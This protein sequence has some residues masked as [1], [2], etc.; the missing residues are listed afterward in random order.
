[1][2]GRGL[3]IG[4]PLTGQTRTNRTGIYRRLAW[5]GVIC[6][7]AGLAALLV[8]YR[9]S[10]NPLAVH[11]RD[12]QFAAAKAEL[13]VDTPVSQLGDQS[14]DPNLGLISH[15]AITD[16]LFLKSDVARR[17]AAAAAGIPGKEISVSGPFTL[18]IGRTNHPVTGPQI[19]EPVQEDKDYRLLVDVDGRHPMI[20]LYSQAPNTTAAVAIVDS[21]RRLLTRYVSEL[22]ST[23]HLGP[24]FRSVIR[25]LGET[26]SGVVDGGARVRLIG[27]TFLLVFILGGGLLLAVEHRRR[28]GPADLALGRL[29]ESS[30]A[31]DE[32]PHTR[33]LLPWSLAMFV[34]MI[35]LV[36][37]D[38]MS[39]PVH[40]PLN[41]KPD[42]ALLVAI[43]LIW[44]STLALVSGAA[45]PRLQLTKV[46]YAV[47]VFVA[48]CLASVA[49]NGHT[50]GVN[51]EVG[52]VFKKLLLLG[53]FV[54]F[55]VVAASVLR[56]GE[57]PQFIKLMIGLGVIVAIASV[58]E[59][60]M[61]YNVFYSWWGKIVPLQLPPELDK[62][63]GIGRLSVDG[64]TAEPLELAALLAI[65]LPFAI[66]GAAQARTMRRRLIYLLA[67]AI[68]IGGSF[69]T[70]RKTGV[71]APV[72]GL[73]VL[74]AYRPRVMLRGLLIVSLPMFVIVHL[75][76]PGQIGSTFVQLLPGHANTA[77][78]TRD[79]EARYDAI[80]PDVMS[81]LLIGRG[82]QSYDPL[83]YRILDNEFLGLAIGVGLIGLVSY[84]VIFGVLL[85]MAHP[86]IRGPD[87]RRAAAALGLQAAVVTTCVANSL[88]DELSFTHVSYLFFFLAAMVVA[89]RVPTP[90][91]PE[92]RYR[93]GAPALPDRR[94]AHGWGPLPAGPVRVGNGRTQHSLRPTRSQRI[95]PP[96]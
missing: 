5:L 2:P 63:D 65:V 3:N 16:A 4:A 26:T 69:A 51:Q 55:F 85:A 94:P 78:T 32:W 7:L 29:G 11:P 57:V 50:L 44:V 66:V 14:Q 52:P 70:G 81:H 79:R 93:R 90:V 74:V 21:A 27:F 19:P 40:L 10:L 59:R 8:A 73:L 68:L 18:L 83:K 61:K 92:T 72:C 43:G 37:V 13:L 77:L 84:L 36:P 54:F 53:S 35:F 89:L 67:V 31:A 17:A 75:M 47:F 80:R 24:A 87:P 91:R 76:A 39:L 86:M 82:F 23:Q 56:P 6:A 62:I 9:V 41:S 64:P 30:G 25:P 28:H 48:L 49:L 42:R 58:V 1:V 95:N 20:T 34:L 38:A 88:F 71:L 12:V 45:R 46:H 15:L 22:E 33:R 60:T 96:H